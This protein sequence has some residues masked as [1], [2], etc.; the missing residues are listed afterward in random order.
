MM[1][2]RL[3]PSV[4]SAIFAVAVAWLAVSASAAARQQPPLPV[5][6]PRLEE[7]RQAYEATN[8]EAARD[9]L[10]AIIA[11]LSAGTLEPAQRPVL[12]GS[13]ELRGRARQNL[14][15]VEGARTDF[16]ALLF[17]DPSYT[18]PAQAGPRALELFEEVRKTTVGQVMIRVTPQDANVTLDGARLVDRSATLT[19]VGGAHTVAATRTGHRAAAE[20]FTIV[21]GEPVRTIEL[22]LDRESSTLT[23]MTAPSNVEVVLDGASRGLTEPDPNAAVAAN[24]GEA[25]PS[26]PFLIEELRAGRHRLEFKRDCYIG[27]EQNVDIARPDDV[28]IPTVRLERAVAQV[29]VSAE[30]SG[31]TVFLDETPQG[32]PPQVLDVCQGPHTVEVRTQTGRHVKR[33]N[34]KPR[35]AET[36]VANVRPAFGIVSD[37]GANEGVRGGP[38]R[39]L[40]AETA[41]QDLKTLTLF[42]TPETRTKELTAADQ[43]PMDWLAFN[44]RRMP[45]KGAS[46]IGAP[47]RRQIGA[48][49]AKSFEIQGIA[50]VARDPDGDQSDMLLMLLAPGSATPDVLRWKLDN[51]VTVRQAIARLDDVPLVTRGSLGLLAID[52]LDA[53]GAV[54]VTVQPG[55]SAAAASIQ[56]G[57]R[58]VSAGGAPIKSA[59]QLVGLVNTH[60][61]NQPLSLDIQDR[62]GATRK[63]D[64]TLQRVPRLVELLDQT[65]LSNALAVQYAS[66]AY[67]SATPL[68]EAAVRL[69]LAAALMRLENWVDAMRELEAV[70][71]IA[72]GPALPQAVKDAVAGTVQYLTG[73][74]AEALGDVAGAERAWAQ[75]SQSAS[76][77]L[78]DSAEP[79]KELSERRLAQLRQAR[80][81][82]R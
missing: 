3:A 67:S 29:T 11:R 39:R 69:N 18:L 2:M 54:V 66:R 68:D 1:R 32:A 59:A 21:P 48:R 49:L 42:A 24:V 50:A 20:T 8:Y 38:D 81:I 45:I 25:A 76:A 79:L 7:A 65:V 44:T 52:V 70:G 36:F 75:S 31:G 33:L 17:V 28:V 26:K 13:Y 57:D 72:A 37:S 34:I 56:P 35:Q 15:D 19:L 9:L 4:T 58:I 60:P 41:F 77:L 82:T 46:T 73:A 30:A 71:K 78:T 61:A 40:E 62:A 51:P 14:R 43:L 6:D 5:T 63:V 23:L 55:G 27:V 53:D 80:G 74:C 16:R 64:V 10:D 47:A 12:A 22:T